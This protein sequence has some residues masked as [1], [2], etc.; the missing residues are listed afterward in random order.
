MARL[1]QD[2]IIQDH[3]ERIAGLD[4]QI[5]D[6][7]NARLTLVL[8]LKAHKAAR[9]LAFHD[10][11]QEGRVLADLHQANRGP[12]SGEGLEAIFRFILARI[13]REAE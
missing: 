1:T 4:R 10:P 13:K 9:G 5:L 12:L 7:L 6:A 3:R 8:R 11:A 2:P